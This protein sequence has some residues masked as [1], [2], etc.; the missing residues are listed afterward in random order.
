MES[1]KISSLSYIR[2]IACIGVCIL[3]VFFAGAGLPTATETGAMVSSCI[4]NCM[5]FA[6]PCFVMVTGALLLDPEKKM[7]K[8]KVLSYIL[9]MLGVLAIFTFVYEIIDELADGTFGLGNLIRTWWN[10]FFFNGSWGHVWYLYLIIA[11]YITL[12]YSRIISRHLRDKDYLNLLVLLFVFM[13]VVPTISSL[14]GKTVA[15]YICVYTVYPFFFFAGYAIRKGILNID[16]KICLIT[17]IVGELIMIICTA[18]KVKGV[19]SY[20]FVP[21]LIVAVAL[22]GW[23]FRIEVSEESKLGKALLWADKYSFA[24]YLTHMFYIK[25]FFSILKWDPYK[26]ALL[27]FIIL[28]L[29]I[30]CAFATAVVLKMIPGLKKLL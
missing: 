26:N 13:S 14:A 8:K 29:V 5:L 6:V 11:L 28:V 12:P 4:R 27:Y 15:F 23:L 2:A 10:E 20:S 30:V 16:S 21:A 25:L 22:F 9:R 17:A 18:C 24:V 3:H 1:K 19:G 7:G